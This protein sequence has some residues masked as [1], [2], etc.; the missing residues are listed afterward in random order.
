MPFQGFYK[1][2]GHY[3][4]L[5][6]FYIGDFNYVATDGRMF[7]LKFS[8]QALMLEK[9]ILFNDQ[10][11]VN[12]IVAS[13]DP[14]KVKSLGRSVKNYIDSKWNDIRYGIMVRILKYKFQY[15]KQSILNELLEVVRN[16][17]EFV[18]ESPNDRIWGAKILPNGTLDGQNLLGRA[19]NEVLAEMLS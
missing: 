18:E 4:V 12:A 8:E 10:E 19:A 2:S 16:K 3:G 14:R 15:I 13:N 5:S 17:Y 1:Q 9:A 6:N 7:A 11:S